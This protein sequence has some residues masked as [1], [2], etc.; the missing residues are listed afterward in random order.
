MFSFYIY[1]GYV[2]GEFFRVILFLPQIISMTVFALLFKYIVTDAYI[3]AMDKLFSEEVL[4]LFDNNTTRLG[5]VLFFNIWVSYGTTVLMF[6]GAMSGI[7]ISL[8]EAAKIDGANIIQ[9]FVHITIPAI[10]STIIS[11]FVIILAQ[12]FTSDMNLY[13]LFGKNAMEIGT[14]GYF[15]YTS[16][17]ESDIIPIVDTY[18]SYSEIAALGL[19]ITCI[20]A[21]T[22][23]LAKKL[24]EKVGPSVD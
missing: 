22:T 10:Y 24:L 1:K 5:T 23:L 9:E 15:I 19:I 7:D 20:L 18:L 13:T 21:P 16:T 8:V 6:S 17:L 12:I 2:G 14:L 11:F 3:V 4:G